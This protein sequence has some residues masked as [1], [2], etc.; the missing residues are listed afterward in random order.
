[1][2][3]NVN[4][5]I[6]S[7]LGYKKDWEDAN[8]AGD[9]V[10]ANTA[11][12]K[13]KGYYAQL[14]ASGYKDVADT[15]SKS[16]YSNAQRYADKF[17]NTSGKTAFRPYIYGLAKNKG[18][19]ESDIAKDI[20][21]NETTGEVSLGGRNLG[22]PLAEYDGVSYWNAADI[23]NAF[24]EYYSGK[25]L[26]SDQLYNKT[27][28]DINDRSSEQWDQISADKADVQSK[29]GELY[30]Y[31][32]SNPYETEEGKAIMSRYNLAGLNARDNAIALGAASNGGNIDSSSAA[33][34]MRQQ[35]ALT[36]QGQTAVENMY[37]TRI[38]RVNQILQNL[39]A[40]NASTYEAQNANMNNALNYA[41]NLFANSEAERLNDDSIKSNEVARQAAIADITGYTPAYMLSTEY[42]NS[43][44]TL[45]NADV[46]YTERINALEAELANTTDSEKKSQIQNQ[47][48]QLYTAR[49]AKILDP[50]GRWS[51]YSNLLKT[52]TPVQTESARQ[53]DITASLEDKSIDSAERVAAGQNATELQMNAN[54]N[55]T[56]LTAATMKS[57]K[58]DEDTVEVFSADEFKTSV[59]DAAAKEAGLDKH[60]VAL[61][62]RLRQ[63]AEYNGGFLPAENIKNIAVTY[64]RDHGVDKAQLEK[65]FVYLGV[66]AD[67]SD[68]VN[69][70][71]DY[72]DGVTYREKGD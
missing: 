41:N 48:N 62:N 55:A 44:G 16:D 66:N 47:L 20:S 6:N 31:A 34:A 69:V 4:K 5:T 9:A 11:A 59:D 67:L 37:G 70:S 65:V 46:D 58:S 19:S 68:V 38:D 17:I 40:Q 26:S 24:N 33:N 35:M 13:A 49:N 15:L 28:N 64:S 42:F 52:V 56:A 2:T 43:D 54:D 10:A 18:I 57:E 23:E 7:I 22:R 61:L 30:D 3:Y 63:L 36:G 50:S 53:F 1:M 72:H 25:Q 14:E 29:I 71:D 51:G 27:I 45:K 12:D 60:G 21:F 39:G 8:K 32:M